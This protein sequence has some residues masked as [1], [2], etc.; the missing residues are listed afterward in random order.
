MGCHST[1]I[2]TETITPLESPPKKR[3]RVHSP[4]AEIEVDVS[5]PEPPSKKA[6]RKAKKARTTPASTKL[7]EGA[8]TVPFLTS[9]TEEDLAKP[10]KLPSR[11]EYGIWIG[12]L[13]WTATKLNLRSFLTID[14]DISDDSITRLHMPPPSKTA[15]ESLRQKIKPQNRGFAYVDFSSEAALMKAL[16]LSER[17]VKGRRVLIKDARSF[18][19]RPEKPKVEGASPA[20]SGK[21]AFKRVFVGNLGFDTTKEMLQDHFSRCGEVLDVHVATFEDTGK[22]K[23]F[24]WVE[25]ADLEA[26]ELAVRGWVNYEQKHGAG[27]EDHEEIE[28]LEDQAKSKQKPKIRK[29]WVN[30]LGGRTLRTEFAEG[31]DVRYKKRY[32]KDGTAR[33]D[34]ETGED[35]EPQPT[36][37]SV[38]GESTS[39]W[40]S[41]GNV[42][43]TTP[44][45][46]LD[47]RKIKPGAALA[48]APRLTGGIIESQGKKT[49]FA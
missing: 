3:K 24:A 33:K 12:N 45:R 32:G 9:A 41:K 25:F 31:K 46:R 5:A 27:D 47:A 13:P 19:G 38:N 28:P 21:P 20:S 43:R 18:K 2:V 35:P 37:K 23:G 1:A 16:T 44:T 6:L 42:I 48:A 11:S 40:E 34:S 14:T 10:N 15:V 7:Q 49:V 30:R 22:C 29:W 26:G 17:L 4:P 8:S 36:A 39:A